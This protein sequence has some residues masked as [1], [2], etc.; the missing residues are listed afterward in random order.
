MRANASAQAVEFVAGNVVAL[1]SVPFCALD[2]P[3]AG[4]LHKRAGPEP[5]RHLEG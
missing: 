2:S 4:N 5:V 3:Q 1:K